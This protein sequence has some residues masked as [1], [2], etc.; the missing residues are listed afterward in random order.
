[1]TKNLK[2][3]N[4][5]TKVSILSVLS[6]I[7][8]NFR[9]PIPIA[10]AFYE[11]DFVNVP[12]LIGGFALGPFAAF[13][14]EVIRTI[15][16]LIFVPTSSF[17]VGE[18]SALIVNLA[19]VVPAAYFYKKHKT[20][21]G[22]ILALLIGSVCFVLAGALSNYYFILPAYVKLMNFPA[23]KIISLGK[24][25]NSNV[26][27]FFSLVIICTTPFNIVKSLLTSLLVALLYKKI[28]FLLKN[29]YFK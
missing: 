2:T 8:I 28:S 16:K 23:E 1:M 19:F 24:A 15:L 12:T 22:A 4:F 18:T 14:I 25:I 11:M 10:P 3:I 5:I 27:S 7:L 21:K 26:N 6:F 20:F 9:F 29:T 13:T 17:F